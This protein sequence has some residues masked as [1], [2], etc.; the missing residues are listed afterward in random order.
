MIRAA[1]GLV[2]MEQVKLA[3]LAGLDR[4]TLNRI[5]SA[6]ELPNNPRQR[7]SFLAIRNVLEKEHVVFVY[8][9]KSRGEGVVMKKG[10]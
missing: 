9:D 7:A 8:P 5:E 1:R 2:D 4:R 10:N 6:K 3:E